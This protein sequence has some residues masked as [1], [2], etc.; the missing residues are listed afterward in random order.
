MSQSKRQIL[1][2]A[3]ELFERM[4]YNKTTLTDIAHSVGK[5]K[6]AIYYYFK[7]KEEIFAYIVRMEAEKFQ[8]RVT[9]AVDEKEDPTEKLETYIETRI[10]LMLKISKRYKFLK[11]E[12]FQLMPIVEKNREAYH[13]QEIELITQILAEG[14]ERQTFQVES[15]KFAA[16]MLVN[17]LKGLEVQMYVTDELPAQDININ[18][19][20]QFLL[21][22]IIQKK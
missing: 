20:K 12:F 18:H 6:T 21:Y 3:N 5:V 17:S 19:L 4:G 11:K 16:S 22:G 14:K 9:K 15:P 7:S 1:S 13:K 10:T 2:S 8:S